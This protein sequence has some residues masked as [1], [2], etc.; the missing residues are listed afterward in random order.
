MSARYYLHFIKKISPHNLILNYSSRRITRDDAARAKWNGPKMILWQYFLHHPYQKLLVGI[1]LGHVGEILSIFY[2]K[3]LT[4]YYDTQLS[5]S[6][7]NERWC[8]KIR[9]KSSRNDIV[10][11]FP[12]SPISEVARRHQIVVIQYISIITR[13]VDVHDKAIWLIRNTMQ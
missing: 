13:S 10:G 11:V 5:I 12:S 4:T 7:H 1:K 6:T 8:R 9:E 2:Q 3:N